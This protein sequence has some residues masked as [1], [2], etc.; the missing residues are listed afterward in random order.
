[1]SDS[2]RVLFDVAEAATAKA[3]RSPR[4]GMRTCSWPGCK[5]MVRAKL[6]GCRP[7]WERLPK[8]LRSRIW[9]AYR[10]GQEIDGKLSEAYVKAFSA[11]Q[12]WIARHGGE[13]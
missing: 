3:E 11:V 10:P 6:W 13:V 9:Y 2:Q 12:T 5:V 7:H 1:M 4:P 8:P